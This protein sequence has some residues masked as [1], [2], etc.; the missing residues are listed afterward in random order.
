[1]RLLSAALA[2][3]LLLAACGG[4][5]GSDATPTAGRSATRPAATQPA[6][7]A[8]PAAVTTPAAAT[9]TTAPPSAANTPAPPPPPPPPAAA[10]NTPL[11]PPPPP[12]PS[13][14]LDLIALDV[15]FN[16]TTLSAAAG[17]SITIR[18]SNQDDGVQ[19]NVRV[20]AGS[21]LASPSIGATAIETG[22]IEQRLNLGVLA[23]GQ[24]SYM[25]D[26]HPTT[27]SGS[28]SVN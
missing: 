10:T 17:S 12:G 7:T 20:R 14:T 23:A 24:Y 1:M 11:P 2:A 15:L 28:L 16:T 22:P 27:M 21:S 13:V 8:T 19:H 3:A 5:D 18:L 9:T 4:G 6:S 26:V 25:C